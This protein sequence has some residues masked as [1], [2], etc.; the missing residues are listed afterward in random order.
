M[1]RLILATT[2]L[3]PIGCAGVPATQQTA[4]FEK[5]ALESVRVTLAG[6]EIPVIISSR[7]LT[8]FETN[9]NSPAREHVRQLMLAA[10]SS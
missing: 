10:H 8:A 5:P 6:T 1:K 7:P 3:L 4:S 9:Q 2:F